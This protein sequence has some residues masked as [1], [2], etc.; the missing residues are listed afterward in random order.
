VTAGGRFHTSP[1]R[2][3]GEALSLAPGL[4]KCYDY[5]VKRWIVAIVALVMVSAVVIYVWS[6][7]LDVH[8]RDIESVMIDPYPEGPPGPTFMRRPKPDRQLH[9]A[10]DLIEAFIPDPLPRTAWQGLSCGTGGNLIVTVRDGDTITYGPCR[11]PDS[12]NQLW[13]HMVDIASGGACRPGCDPD[14]RLL[15]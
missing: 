15:H 14:D 13:A 6:R 12:I 8:V 5:V 9:L 2:T 10:F 3:S 7:P 1:R 11:R 4:L